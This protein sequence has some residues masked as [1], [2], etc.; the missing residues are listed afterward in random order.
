[1]LLEITLVTLLLNGKRVVVPP[2]II[3]HQRIEAHAE[4]C[5][6]N[7]L[8]TYYCPKLSQEL[9]LSQGDDNAIVPKIRGAPSPHGHHGGPPD[10][11][12]D[13][14]HGHG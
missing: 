4:Y 12:H 1:M 11:S 6:F 13:R 2:E 9:T 3:E 10:H 14:G 8:D 7:P 5:R